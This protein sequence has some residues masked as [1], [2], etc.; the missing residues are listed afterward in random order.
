MAGSNQT[1]AN[2]QF[3]R[4][5]VNVRAMALI[6]AVIVVTAIVLHVALYWL[7]GAFR[8]SA[9]ESGRVTKTQEQIEQPTSGQPRLQVDPT[10]DI[11]QFRDEENKKLSTYGW[12][13]KDNG[14][15]RIPIEQAM[16]LVASGRIVSAD[17]AKPVNPGQSAGV[18]QKVNKA[19]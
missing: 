4:R 15:V 11:N 13:N 14:I 17:T 18:A 8:S 3:E 6:G 2:V 10:T 1:N 12:V 5:D 19:K 7:Y 16:K 9:A